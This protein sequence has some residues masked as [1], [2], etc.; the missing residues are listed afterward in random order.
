VAAQQATQAGTSA[1]ASTNS[2]VLTFEVA[3]DQALQIINA[4]QGG[5]QIYLVLLA[6][7]QPA[8]TAGAAKTAAS[9]K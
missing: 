4:N 7:D 9:S 8:P 6:P 1:A 2:G 3:Q 5:S